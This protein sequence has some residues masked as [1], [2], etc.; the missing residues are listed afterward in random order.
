MRVKTYNYDAS[1]TLWVTKHTTHLATTLC[2]KIT[3]SW[4]SRVHHSKQFSGL[5]YN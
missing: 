5:T 2:T 1:V 4:C 3:Y